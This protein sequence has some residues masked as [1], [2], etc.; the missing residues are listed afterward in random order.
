MLCAERELQSFVLMH[1]DKLK[2]ECKHS[3]CFLADIRSVDQS[4]YLL[5]NNILHVGVSAIYSI[6]TK[7][8]YR[9]SVVSGFQGGTNVASVVFRFNLH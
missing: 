3:L 4:L 2:I 8:I 1:K 7:G 9:L 6:D 5:T